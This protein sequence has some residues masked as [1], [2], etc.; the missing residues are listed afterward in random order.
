MSG[1]LDSIVQRSFQPETVA[2]ARPR[3]PSRFETAAPTEIAFHTAAAEDRAAERAQVAEVR[4][5]RVAPLPAMTVEPVAAEPA[6]AAPVIRPASAT[7]VQRQTVT[8]RIEETVRISEPQEPAAPERA[9]VQPAPVRPKVTIKEQPSSPQ[10]ERMGA[11][12]V[13]R[14]V[15]EI[16]AQREASAISRQTPVTGAAGRI[17][18]EQTQARAP[19]VKIAIGRIEIRAPQPAPKPQPAPVRRA[20]GIRPVRD[21]STYLRDRGAKS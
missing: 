15:R 6:Q 3:L 2:V 19:V 8:E 16:A 20:Q 9:P 14:I 21:L 1:F 4:G 7:I 10:V 18:P 17:E 13:D 12:R 11:T 5:E